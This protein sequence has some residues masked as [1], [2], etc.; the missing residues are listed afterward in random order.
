MKTEDVLLIILVYDL[1]IYQVMFLL[2]LRTT[3]C[4]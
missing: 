4:L 1:G 2:F 3:L